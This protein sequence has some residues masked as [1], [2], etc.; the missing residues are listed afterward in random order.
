MIAID[1]HNRFLAT[2]RSTV[3]IVST[4]LDLEYLCWYFARAETMSINP[5]LPG[6]KHRIAKHCAQLF[7]I[8]QQQ[9]KRIASN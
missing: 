2:S 8:I 3:S 6:C 4:V 9:N 1:N 5:L 7:V